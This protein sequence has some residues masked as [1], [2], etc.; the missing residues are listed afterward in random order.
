MQIESEDEEDYDHDDSELN[1]EW[2]MM[3]LRFS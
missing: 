2:F 1:C 3:W